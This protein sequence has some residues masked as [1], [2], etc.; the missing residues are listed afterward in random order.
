MTSKRRFAYKCDKV[1]WLI[2]ALLPVIAF[3]VVNFRSASSQDF[4][5]Y[6]EAWQFDFI[7]NAFESAFT[8]ANFGALA[9]FS[10]LSYVAGVEIAHCL[11]DIVVFIPRLAHKFIGKAVQDD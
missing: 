7:Y 6:M 2:V 11:F 10:Y 5:V 3:F 9:C 8:T 4:L 1:F